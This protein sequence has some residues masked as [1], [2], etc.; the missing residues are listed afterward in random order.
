MLLDLLQ[1][2]PAGADK[3]EHVIV[4]ERMREL[5]YI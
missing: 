3:N 4:D 2:T 1:D 5:G